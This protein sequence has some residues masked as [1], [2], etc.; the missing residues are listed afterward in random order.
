MLQC[1]IYL[2]YIYFGDIINPS[3]NKFGREIRPELT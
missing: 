1:F 2:K 3:L